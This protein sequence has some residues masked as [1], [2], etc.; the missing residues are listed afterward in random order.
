[1][2]RLYS[3]RLLDGKLF[4]NFTRRRMAHVLIA[5]LVNF[6]TVSVPLMM[7]LP[8]C[9]LALDAE[10][11]V[12]RQVNRIEEAMVINLVFCFILGIYFGVVSTS[13]MMRR[14]SAYFWHALPEKRETLYTTSI[15]SA[16]TCAAIGTL[17]GLA[18]T[19]TVLATNSAMVSA[20]LSRFFALALKNLIYFAVTYAITVFAGSFTGNGVIQA[21]MSLVVMFYPIALFYG[22][23]ILRDINVRYLDI[24]YY[25]DTPLYIG[26]S[27]VTH[28]A[29]YYLKGFS[30]VPTVLAVVSVALLLFAGLLIY[31]RRAIESSEQPI[32]FKK[33]GSVIKYLLI[34]V[35][36]VYVGLFFE[37]L[38]GGGWMIF[39]FVCGGVLCSMLV[40]TI[41]AKSP[42][43]MFRGLRGLCIFA[44]AFALFFA[45][46]GMDVFN[47]DDR[48]PSAESLSSVDVRV[49]RYR[50]G[51]HEYRIDGE[52]MN[53]VLK[54][55]E[56]Q[57]AADDQNLFNLHS[58]V[59]G[60]V[61]SLNIV[62][63]T[64][65]GIPIARSYVIDKTTE[66]ARDFLRL[67]ADSG[68]VDKCFEENDELANTEKVSVN[69]CMTLGY[70]K[71]TVDVKFDYAEFWALYRR[72]IGALN[73][74]RLS[75]A[76]IGILRIENMYIDGEYI[77]YSTMCLIA[78]K[79]PLYE[80]M[81]E[82]LA[83]LRALDQMGYVTDEKIL[84]GAMI[85][86]TDP[87]VPH[88]TDDLVTGD[89]Y[90]GYGFEMPL[91]DY[92]SDIDT[93]FG[94]QYPSVSL[95]ATEAEAL[96]PSLEVWSSPFS[97]FTDIDTT[98]IAVLNYAY[99]VSDAEATKYGYDTTTVHSGERFCFV[100]G[101][102]PESVKKMFE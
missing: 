21:L 75:A 11:I 87:R 19:I 89:S 34:T 2:Q 63:R 9:L 67:Y 13:Y 98:Y 54:M 49:N 90:S 73:Y 42:K 76:P 96:L 80:D 86:K 92:T 72:E 22:V 1:M 37:V 85:Y 47:T 43:A 81:T 20:V 71:S 59:D 57:V 8:R 38:G 102:V 66:G 84:T 91:V 45:V 5:F 94:G 52:E 64:K 6:F 29:L 101:G 51:E 99:S 40:N 100:S 93:T 3:E 41:L 12:R 50:L 26:S 62:M 27:P 10:E 14:R 70:G 30:A 35:V 25:L 36:T 77:G 82:T 44:V 83:Y 18:V 39:G 31:R 23:I 58:T 65:L 24:N 53:T 60:G 79:L 46:W 33:L 28:A 61:F 4:G 78:N 15:V 48:V 32:V 17:I 74:E 69:A 97:I 55:L 88:Y 68:I 16:L 95:S 7:A 56:N